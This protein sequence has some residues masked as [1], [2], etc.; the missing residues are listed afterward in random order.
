MKQEVPVLDA[1]GMLA[2]EVITQPYESLRHSSACCVMQTTPHLCHLALRSVDHPTGNCAL[3]VNGDEA[4]QLAFV[5]L[6]LV[7]DTD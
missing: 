3:G 1:V 6:A 5:R 7:T 2:L 4:S